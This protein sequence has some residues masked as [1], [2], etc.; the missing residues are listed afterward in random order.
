MEL[1][2][3]VNRMRHV[4]EWMSFLIAERCRGRYVAPWVQD[5]DSFIDS[6]PTYEKIANGT[7]QSVPWIRDLLHE[8][9]LMGLKIKS[10]FENLQSQLRQQGRKACVCRCVFEANGDTDYIGKK[11]LHINQV[12]EMV[13]A[14]F[15][16]P[17]GLT[18]LI[19][20]PASLSLATEGYDRSIIIQVAELLYGP[21][22]RESDVEIFR[23]MQDAIKKNGITPLPFKIFENEIQS[24]AWVKN[25]PKSYNT[26][27]WVAI[28]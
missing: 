27:V 28:E 14:D 12:A 24:V 21:P 3:F 1:S 20:L 19:R 11:N 15:R 8:Q 18:N 22:K 17:Y 9:F 6:M 4:S 16:S 7:Y 13:D 10:S 5:L 23:K 2:A 26:F 25:G